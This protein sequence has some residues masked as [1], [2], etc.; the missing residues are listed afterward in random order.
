MAR[1]LA[2]SSVL[3]G[4]A[5]LV[6]DKVFRL[7]N[8]NDATFSQIVIASATGA[9][10][11]ITVASPMDVVKTRI[12]KQP[13]EDPITGTSIVK[14]MIK[15]EGFGSF[16]KGLVP[17]V[18]VLGPKLIFAFSVTQYMSVLIDE[19]VRCHLLEEKKE[20]LRWKWF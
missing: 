19:M 11:C 6:K 17:K 4:G 7:H 9:L 14:N 15:Y 3:F 5:C 12:Q 20:S 1:N 16:W 8:H 2:G 18:L 13:F 10:A